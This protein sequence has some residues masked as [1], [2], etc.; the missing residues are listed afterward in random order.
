MEQWSYMGPSAPFNVYGV[1]QKQ[2]KTTLSFFCQAPKNYWHS[3]AHVTTAP[4]KLF[5]TVVMQRGGT[6][7]SG[8][9]FK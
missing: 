8:P 9:S 7:V 1:D 5:L 6:G 4:F 3:R 2:S